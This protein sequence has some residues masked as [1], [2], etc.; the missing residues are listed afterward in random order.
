M[1][2]QDPVVGGTVLIR[3]AIRSPNYVPGVSGW[4]VNIDGSAEFNN[5][6]IRGEFRGN[7]FILNSDGFFMYS[8]VPGAGN[9]IASIAASSGNDEFGNP[10]LVGLMNYQGTGFTGFSGGNVYFGDI[11]DGFPV[12]AFIGAVGTTGITIFSPQTNDPDQSAVTL[13]EGDTSL[14]WSDNNYPRF[15]FESGTMVRVQNAIAK[16]SGTT[17]ETWQTPTFNANWATTGTLN[18]NSTF[19]GLQYRKDAEDNVW[20]YGAAV[21]SG[22]GASVFTLPAGY[23]PPANNRAMIPVWIFDASA[24]T[25]DGHL[26]QVT[27][28]GV[29]NLAASLTGITIAAGDQIFFNGKF[30][31]GNLS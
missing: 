13:S 21:A 24:G 19:H 1:T 5:L 25:V 4:S 22:A 12:A 16:A 15:D 23:R 10:Y 14:G 6:T 29:V 9:L 26:A 8:G 28:T 30:P 17:I 18:G 27:D 11:A 7:N 31:L 20:L 2:F 3:P